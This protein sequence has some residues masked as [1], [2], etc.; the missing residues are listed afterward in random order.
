MAINMK[1]YLA[2]F[3]II[4]TFCKDIDAHMYS[5]NISVPI[6]PPIGYEWILPISLLILTIGNIIGLHLIYFSSWKKAFLFS[7]IGITFYYYFSL[8]T[9]FIIAFIFV[10]NLNVKI[11]QKIF[12]SPMLFGSLVGIFWFMEPHSLCHGSE[13]GLGPPYPV[14]WG[15]NWSVVGILFFKWNLFI[16]LPLII[17]ILFLTSFFK[18][19]IFQIGALIG[20]NFLLYFICIIPFIADGALSHGWTGGYV[21]KACNERKAILSDA[22]KKYIEKNGGKPPSYNSIQELFPELLPYIGEIKELWEFRML[23]NKFT[24]HIWI[25]PGEFAFNKKPKSYFIYPQKIRDHQSIFLDKIHTLISCPYH[26][27]GKSVFIP[28]K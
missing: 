28:K 27:N 18:T 6:Y 9:L 14:F 11:W 1:Q 19:Q 25:C 12:L 22:L 16:F 23:H 26:K 24:S 3:I 5:I 15:F 20:L 4:I 21:F 8:I 2:I 13:V 17:S 7:I 10:Y